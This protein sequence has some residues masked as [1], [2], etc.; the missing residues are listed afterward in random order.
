MSY[1]CGVCGACSPDGQQ[2]LLYVVYHVV[3]G[4]EVL[5]SGQTY[6]IKYAKPKKDIA[7]E[8]PVCRDCKRELEFTTLAELLRR[9]RGVEE[10]A[11]DMTE[12][13][14]PLPFQPVRLGKPEGA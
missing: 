2:R 14:I 12:A 13:P 11:T 10:P 9:M 1:R 3:E 8:I 5:L 7:R 4:R 6:F